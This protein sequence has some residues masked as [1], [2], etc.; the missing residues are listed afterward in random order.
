MDFYTPEKFSFSQ[1]FLDQ[2]LVQKPAQPSK[3]KESQTAFS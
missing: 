1:I 3:A 2:P